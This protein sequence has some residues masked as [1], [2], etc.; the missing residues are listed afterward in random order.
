MKNFS[1]SHD[2]PWRHLGV[3]HLFSACAA[4]IF[5]ALNLLHEAAP[6]ILERSRTKFV[7]NFI[8]AMSLFSYDEAIYAYITLLWQMTD[9]SKVLIPLSLD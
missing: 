6:Q 7:A 8:S 2:R 1:L 9:S 5:Q 4:A 3:G